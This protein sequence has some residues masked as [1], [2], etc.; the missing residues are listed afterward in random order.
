MRSLDGVSPGAKVPLS[1]RTPFKAVL[2]DLY[3]TLV[4]LDTAVS[5]AGRQ[6]MAD[7]LGVPLDSFTREWRRSVADRMMGRGGSL[8]DHLAATA[9]AQGCRPTAELIGDMV[10]IERRR[11]ESSVHLYPDAVPLL[12]KLF[13]QGCRLGLLSNVSDGAAVPIYHLGVDALFHQMILSHE[14]GLLKPDPAIFRLACERLGV[15]PEETAFVADGGFSELDAAFDMG[16]YSIQV[17]QENQSPDFGSSSRYHAT[18][19]GLSQV[20]AL[21]CLGGTGEGGQAG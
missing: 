13:S 14:V 12:R 8:R 2:F 7:R 19:R 15:P 5:D 18:A 10:E 20:E 11:L 1:P 16:I 6:A 17:V 21:L 3:D 4:W 9:G